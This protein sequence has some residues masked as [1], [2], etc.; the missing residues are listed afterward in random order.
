MFL[1][2]SR[3]LVPTPFAL[4]VTMETVIVLF[5]C[6]YN[7]TPTPAVGSVALETVDDD[8]EDSEGRPVFDSVKGH[9]GALDTALAASGFTKKNQ[10]ELEKAKEESANSQI[11][12]E[13]E[14]QTGS[15]SESDSEAETLSESQSE[16][17]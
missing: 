17:L 15:E 3:R 12:T 2:P 10:E 1:E 5:A 14:I 9:E 11:D 13:T 16:N 8:D 7:Y 6:R 4:F